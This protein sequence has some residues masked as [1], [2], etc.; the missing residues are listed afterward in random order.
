MSTAFRPLAAFVLSSFVILATG[1]SSSDEANSEAAGHITRAETYADQGQYRSAMLEVRNALQK[2]PGNIEHVLVLADIYNTIGAARQATDLLEPWL[3]DHTERVALPLARAYIAQ[4]KHLSARDVLEEY[5]PS[6]DTGQL[7]KPILLAESKRLAG[8]HPEAIS[9]FR[10]VLEENPDQQEAAAGLAKTLLAANEPNAALNLLKEWTERNGENPEL[11]YLQG[12]A[13]YRLGEVEETT[14]VLTDATSAVPSSDVFLPV[15]RNILTLLS[16]SLTEQGRI[17]EAQVYNKILAEN[18]NSDTRER[19]ETAIEAINRGDMDTARTTLE[20]LMRQ[21]PDNEQVALMLGTLKLQEGQ[22]DEAE[23]LL[24]GNIDAET[25][26]TPFIRAA[27]IAQIDSGKREEA[28]RTLSRAIEARPNDPELLAMHG[29]LALS[30]PEHQDSGVASLSKALELDRSSSRLRL[31]L[32]QHY[33]NEG[34]EEQALAQMRVAFTETPTDWSVT[35]NYLGLL[36]QTGR[37]TEAREVKES[38]LNGFSDE[39]RAVTLAAIAEHRLGETEKARARLEEQV[40]NSPDNPMALVALASVHEDEGRADEAAETLLSV[41]ALRPDNIRFLQSAGRAYAKNHTPEEVVAWLL[42]IASRQPELAPNSL[43]LAAQVRAQQGKLAEA[44]DLLAQIPDN[45]QSSMVSAVTGQLLVREAARAADNE[46]WTE[47]RAKAA[48]AIALQPDNLRFALVPV[49]LLAREGKHQEALESLDELETVHGQEPA[50]DLMRA[51]LIASQEGQEAA[52][53]FLEGRWQETGNPELLPILVGLAKEHSPASLDKLTKA[54]VT[55]QPD[56]ATANLTR[57][58]FQMGSGQ[59][60]DAIV[61]YEAALARQ[62]DN[63]IALNNLAWLL[64]ERDQE[65]AIMLAARAQ[66]LAP[67]N[68]AVLDTYGWIL[69]LDGQHQKAVEYLEKALALAPDNSEIA[70]HLKEAQQAL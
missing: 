68:P 64:R 22:R 45:E 34:Q 24:V 13:H 44:R 3:E 59:E 40:Q 23:S 31:A 66:E 57:A 35:Q 17:T 16:R 18:T 4:G 56:S 28:L 67:E 33:M 63:P 53:S 39:P 29:L 52:W 6:S 58:E 65:R 41:A 21:N 70:T 5:S 14:A 62:P 51:R 25:T 26:P 37:E 43:A 7:E 32:A 30:L 1:C 2:D 27:T 60:R 19:A 12:L 8:N 15:R 50:I 20:E 49:N 36:I 47:A 54:W 9:D 69:H 46:N 61:S 10:A 38:L 42:G 11:L 55:A 48:E